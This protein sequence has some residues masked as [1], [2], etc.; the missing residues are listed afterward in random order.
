MTSKLRFKI[1][2]LKSRLRKNILAF[3][4]KNIRGLL[5][6]GTEGYFIVDPADAHVSRQLLDSGSYNSTEVTQIKKYITPQSKILI[7]GGHIGTL[8]V[9]LAKVAKEV[10]VIEANPTTFE[11][12]SLNIR[13]NALSNVKLFNLA[14]NDKPGKLNFLNNTENS[15]G[16]KR[17]PRDR[18][19]N[20]FYDS[21]TIVE[22]ESARLDDIFANETFDIILMD[23]E[24]SEYFAIKGMPKLLGKCRVFIFEFF[25]DHLKHV[26][27]VSVAEFY[28]VIPQAKFT[29][30][31]LPKHNRFCSFE[32][33]KLELDLLHRNNE[34][35]DGVFVFSDI[36][37]Q[38]I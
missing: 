10:S 17:V 12:L 30:A 20:Y 34:N 13:L 28:D 14:A 37:P 35:E 18:K 16:S 2:A 1:W 9:P 23:I 27:G 5:V 33:L 6:T 15:G 3:F 29:K 22:V 32:D 24:G 36:D 7:V 25:P 21:P 38:K 26:S 11:I 4:G 8:V 19:E 31:W